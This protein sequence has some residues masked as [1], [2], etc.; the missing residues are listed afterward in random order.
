MSR[1]K[2]NFINQSKSILISRVNI[3]IIYIQIAVNKNKIIL[4]LFYINVSKTTSGQLLKYNNKYIAINDIIVSF[5]NSVQL[6]VHYFA[7]QPDY[8]VLVYMYSQYLLE[9]YPSRYDT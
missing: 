7:K 1:K 8:Y 4:H 6:I 2:N 5:C 9:M 3:Y